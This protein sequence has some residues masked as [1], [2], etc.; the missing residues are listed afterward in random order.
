MHTRLLPRL[1][2]PY[3][4]RELPG[5]GRLLGLA[6]AYRHEDWKGAGTVQVRDKWHG[7]LMTL[8]LADA[9]D[10]TA[11][12]LARYHELPSQLLMREALRPGDTFVDVGANTGKLT[13]LGAG[14][15]GPRGRVYAFE[16]N[17]HLFARL[18]ADVHANHLNHV[19]LHPAGLGDA[20]AE[21]VLKVLGGEGL[22]GTFAEHAGSEDQPV[23][24]EHRV[25]VLPGDEVLAD[26][27]DAPMAIKIDVEGFECRV[28]K[29]LTRTLS[30]R[31]LVLTEAVPQWLERAG[32]SIA[33][34]FELMTSRGYS[35]SAIGAARRP[36]QH[37]LTLRPVAAAGDLRDTDLLWIHPESPFAKRIRGECFLPA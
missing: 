26:A 5:W 18:T 21:L 19:H 22:L 23:T 27:P 16:P 24:S 33:E 28:L 7:Y 31:P 34:L 20:Q 11:Y 29:G 10:R 2:M 1:I 13:L 6:G 32:S 12:F 15:V 8:D 17:P 36:L 35:A 9:W 14:C 37:R 3:T 4:R 25:Q 30:R